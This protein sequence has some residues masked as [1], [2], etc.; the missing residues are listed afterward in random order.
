MIQIY[1]SNSYAL[2]RRLLIEMVRAERS[3]GGEEL[4]SVFGATSIV[5]PGEA[6]RDDLMRSFARVEGIAS[7]LEMQFLGQWLEPRTG[8]V[9]GKSNRGYELE[10]MVWTL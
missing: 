7:G 8:A 3:A 5:V 6:V 4:A 10:W 1:S 9:V 2:L